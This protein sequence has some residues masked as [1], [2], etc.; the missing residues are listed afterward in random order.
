[1]EPYCQGPIH[2]WAINPHFGKIHAKAIVH[3]YIEI[4]V[5]V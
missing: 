4:C 3:G 2:I 1:M 5:F